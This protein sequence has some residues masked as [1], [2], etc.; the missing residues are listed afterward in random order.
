MLSASDL[1]YVLGE[2]LIATEPARP[3]D[4]ARLMVVHRERDGREP[5]IDH[6]VFRDVGE[7]L[8]AGDLL[9]LNATRVLP[10][11]FLGVRS[12]TGGKAEG[13]YLGPSLEP[14]THWRALVKMKRARPGGRV[15]LLDHAGKPSG[16][17]L[18]LVQRA[19][20]EGEGWLVAVESASPD[21]PAG[22]GALHRVGRTPIPPYIHA[23]RRDRGAN[24][25]DNAD[26]EEYQTVFAHDA[27]ASAPPDLSGSVAAPT[28]GLHFTPELLNQLRLAGVDMC[29]VMLD[30]GLGTFKPIE[31]D[32][33]EHHPMHSEFCWVPKET[34]SAIERCRARGARVIAVGSTAARTLE[35]FETTEALRTSGPRGEHTRLLITP[36]WTWRHVDALITNFH[37]PRTTLLA[38]VAAMMQPACDEPPAESAARLRQVYELAMQERYRFYSFGDAMLIV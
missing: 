11:R 29:E 23:A 31:T 36:G 5:R 13:L 6:R 35:S 34:V 12:D 30:V 33:V 38:M 20:S 18:V 19:A 25:T 2:E 10:A 16:D 26:R 14:G 3:R 37:L 8:R 4:A 28:A 7:Y 21:D 32:R 17:T 27:G 24:V 1:D 22:L 15:D 9:V